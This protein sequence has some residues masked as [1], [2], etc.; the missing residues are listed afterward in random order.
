MGVST[1]EIDR[2][3][4]AIVKAS[5]YCYSPVE[6]TRVSRVGSCFTVAPAPSALERDIVEIFSALSSEM[7]I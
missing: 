7:L 3:V 1:K 5:E 6:S 2:I 4:W